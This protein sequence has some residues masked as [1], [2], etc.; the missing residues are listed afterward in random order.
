MAALPGPRGHLRLVAA[1]PLPWPNNRFDF[2]NVDLGSRRL[3][4]SHIDAGWLVVFY[5]RLV[6]RRE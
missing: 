4:I 6:T 3:Y 2:Q 5:T 1:F